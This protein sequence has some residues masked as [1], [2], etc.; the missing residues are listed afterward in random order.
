MRTRPAQEWTALLDAND[1]PNERLRHYREIAD[2]AQANANDVF[3]RLTY[4]D[5]KTAAMPTP[6]IRF[7]DFGRR[8]TRPTGAIGADTDKVLRELGYSDG[9]IVV[10]HEKK[11]VT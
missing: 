7:S 9:D 2:D 1:I 5:G 8:E 4:S 3:D 10:L 6:P 11:A